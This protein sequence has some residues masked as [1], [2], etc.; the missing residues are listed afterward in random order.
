[1]TKAFAGVLAA[2]T[3]ALALV[4]WLLYRQ[5]EVSQGLRTANAGLV[6]EV[7]G[8]KGQVDMRDRLAEALDAV[9]TTLND[10]RVANQRRFGQVESLIRNIP[11]SEGDSDE[12]IACLSIAVPAALD[13]L[14]RGNQAPAN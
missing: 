1:M 9:Q 3:I 2:L 4:G 8:L 5:I 11:R 12:S 13:G 10:N 7:S 6:A 14:L